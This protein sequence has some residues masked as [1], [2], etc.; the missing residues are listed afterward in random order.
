[1][2]LNNSYN[3]YN[4][5]Y[6]ST[7]YVDFPNKDNYIRQTLQVQYELNNVMDLSVNDIKERQFNLVI[8]GESYPS[9]QYATKGKE[10]IS[11][12]KSIQ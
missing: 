3:K 7:I 12:I 1:M 10:F 9:N 11:N 5:T 6:Q 8:N 2:L 4:N